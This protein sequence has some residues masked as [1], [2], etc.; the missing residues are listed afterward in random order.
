MGPIA[1]FCVAIFGSACPLAPNC[2]GMSVEHPPAYHFE[3]QLIEMAPDGQFKRV[4]APICLNAGDRVVHVAGIG[5]PSRSGQESSWW[6]A[7]CDDEEYEHSSADRASASS[8]STAWNI[9]LGRLDNGNVS[10]DLQV[11]R[12]LPERAVHR[13]VLTQSRQFTLSQ[14]IEPD[15]RQRVVLSRDE[16]GRPTSWLELRLSTGADSDAEV[17]EE[18]PAPPAPVLPFWYEPF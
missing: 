15:Q 4:V 13:G 7:R 9:R 17:Q 10:V 2:W 6:L 12:T 8:Y 18:P 16:S 5:E 14:Q 1:L 11:R 3:A